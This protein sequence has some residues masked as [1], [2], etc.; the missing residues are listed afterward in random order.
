MLFSELKGISYDKFRK[1]IF[2]K[3]CSALDCGC[4]DEDS[5]ILEIDLISRISKNTP[6]CV[7]KQFYID[8]GQNYKFQELYEDVNILE[9]NWRLDCV[10]ASTIC[11]ASIN[12]HFEKYTDDI[13]ND[14]S[15][16]LNSNTLG[17]IKRAEYWRKNKTWMT[18]PVFLKR[19]IDIKL[20]SKKRKDLHLVEGHTRLGMLKGLT[21]KGLLLD[22]SIHKIWVGY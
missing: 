18:P 22:N 20:S 13:K 16:Y 7:L 15:K 6:Y 21:E 14:A 2:I 10:A 4:N 19:N 11:D 17:W 1:N 3:P 8:H 5:G 12:P 9:L